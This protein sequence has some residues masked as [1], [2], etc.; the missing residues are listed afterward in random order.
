MQVLADEATVTP[1]KL[2]VAEVHDRRQ[3]T[4]RYKPEQPAAEHLVMHELYHLRYILEARAEGTNMLFTSGAAARM[5]F[6]KDQAKYRARLIKEGIDAEAADKY[7]G[8]IFDG[9]N[10]QV[11]NAPLDLCIE[12]E[13]YHEQPDM[14]P[15][16]FL[17][18]MELVAVAIHATTDKRIVALSP[19]D[20]LSKSKVYS[21]TLAMLF[22]ELYGV[23]RVADFHV[24]RQ[25]LKQ[26]EGF[27][28][29]YVDYRADREP[30]E[31]YELVEHWAK[32]LQLSPYFKLV[33]EEE[34]LARRRQAQPEPLGAGLEEQLGRIEADPLNQVTEDPAREAEMR[35][36]MEAQQANGLNSAVLMFM[37]DA[38]QHFKGMPKAK[39]KETAF[40]IALLGTQGIEPAKQ[41]YRL[42]NVPGKTFS[43]NHL[44]A[45]YYVSW[46]L[47]IPEMLEQLQLPFD[48]EYAMA[49]EFGKENR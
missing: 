39:I 45:Y 38:L 32:D 30:A 13:M 17:S 8:S 28:E 18:M 9:L 20:I 40:E 49:V 26:A 27:F 47:A 37:V 41:G 42:A 24:T 3:H 16:Q 46:K 15:A 25:E 31:E 2:E 36:F 21:L 10:R 11:F 19:P 48:A 5:Q 7:L 34:H 4:V 23:D 33:P 1:A 29:E 12:Y 22:R 44:L 35:T 6:Q 43:G 14:R